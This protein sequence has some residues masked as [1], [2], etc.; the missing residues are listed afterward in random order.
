MDRPIDMLPRWPHQRFAKREVL[1]LIRLGVRRICVTTP[2]G[3][4]KSLSMTDLAL[5]GMRLGWGVCLFTHRKLL[6]E[7]TINNLSKYGVNY[8]VR[9]ADHVGNPFE[10]F[11]I[12]SVQTEYSRVVKK[13]IWELHNCGMILVDE[14]HL[15]NTT[16]SNEV[17]KLYRDAG[18]FQVGFTATPLGLN[19][20]YDE[21]VQAGNMSELRACGSLVEAVHYGCTEPDLSNIRR[22]NVG[23]D[24]SDPDNVKAIMVPG[25]H[26]RVID[27][28]RRLNPEGHPSIGF[29]PG[30]PE[31]RG[32]CEAFN[33]AGIRS[34][35]ID[36]DFILL[37]GVERPSTKERRDELLALSKSGE[38]RCIWNRFVMREAVDMPWLRH[39]ILAT[40]LG[41][42]GTYLQTGGR[43]LRAYP[44]GDKRNVTVQ[45]HGGNWWRH[46]SLN[47]DRTWKL[48]DTNGLLANLRKDAMAGDGEKEPPEQEPFLCPSCGVALVL[49]NIMRGTLARCSRC[50]HEF[51]FARR[52]RPVLQA[53]GEL[54]EHTGNIFRAKRVERR[55]DT[56]EKWE[57]M[58]WRARRTGTMTFNQAAGLFYRDHGYY[59]PRSMPLMPYTTAEWYQSVKSVEFPRLRP[60]DEGAAE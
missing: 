5:A 2:T 34:A 37:D 29:A 7:Q 32:F 33:K 22:Y 58:F 52:S 36:G 13:G 18:A 10:Q 12:C 57:S 55:P 56:M 16:T 35:H 41:S 15:H 19:G 44:A 4:G 8:G 60:K 6:I 20:Q 9:A 1:D 59:P 46:G 39:G 48:T 47:A 51:D 11:Q 27:H 30:V 31:S 14:A 40:V 49:R 24:I 50:G 3:G 28:Y 45:D 26:G 54:V 43:L 17:F 23:E 25:I 21:L 53:N 42:L 38:V